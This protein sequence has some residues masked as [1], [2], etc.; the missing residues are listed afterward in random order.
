M[1]DPNL[2]TTVAVARRLAELHPAAK[3]PCPACAAEVK[4][5]NLDKHLRKVHA[6]EPGASSGPV[7]LAGVDRRIIAVSLVVL[8]ATMFGTMAVAA[9]A[10]PG[11]GRPL[12]GV[13]AVLLLGAL[14]FM[15]A[16]YVGKFGARV[17]IDDTGISMRWLLGLGNRAV[18]FPV[19]VA[20]GGLR[21]RRSNAVNPLS[22]HPDYV[23]PGPVHSAGGY[24]SLTGANGRRVVLGAKNGP[25]LGKYWDESTIEKSG[26]RFSWD[27]QLDAA[28]L[29]QL[30]YILANRGSLRL[31]S[32]HP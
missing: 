24:I 17:T 28:Q 1:S 27:V 31:R 2:S 8:L 20:T 23:L 32:P 5:E 13:A 11:L 19:T 25:R 4:G 30:Q 15:L 9:L 6:L 10:P 29:A 21:K 12:A 26:P 14:G 18:T 7:V 16:A 3:L 22:R